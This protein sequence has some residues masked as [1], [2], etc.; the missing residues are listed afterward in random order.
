MRTR[1]GCTAMRPAVPGM[2]RAARVTGAWCSNTC[3]TY[4]SPVKLKVPEANPPVHARINAANLALMDETGLSAVEIDPCCTEL[5]ADLERV[6]SDGR[7]GI[8]KS[9]SNKDPYSKRTH[10][11]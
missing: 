11:S 5:I 1:S 6:I 10:M 3:T 7:G 8:L 2:P 9:Y 4:P